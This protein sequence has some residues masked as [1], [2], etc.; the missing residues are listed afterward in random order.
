MSYILAI[1]QGT[2]SSRAIVFDEVGNPVGEGRCPFDQIFP[3]DGWVEQDPEVIWS[4]TLDAARKAIAASPV[5][6]AAIDAI[7]ITNQRETTLLWDAESGQ[8]VHNAIV[9]QDRR[10]AERCVQMQSDGIASA[11]NEITG[12]VIDP[13]FSS[14]KVEWLL[15]DPNIQRLARADHLRFGTV[16]SFLVWRLTGGRSHVTDATNATSTQIFD[17]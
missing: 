12:L 9:W 16:D 14:T 2:S 3:R 17:I 5:D 8:A 15:R 13:Y 10:T 1:D 11:V 6:A 4:T 7:G